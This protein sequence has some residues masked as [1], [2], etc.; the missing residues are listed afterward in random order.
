[1]LTAKNL[2][3]PAVSIG[4]RATVSEAAE[5]MKKQGTGVL[6]VQSGDRPLGIITDRDIAV[7]STADGL[8]PNTVPVEAVMTAEIAGC[9]EDTSADE[10]TS[11]MA[12]RELH[13]LPVFDRESRRVVGILTT[14]EIP[15][16]S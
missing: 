10:A 6:V 7:R 12:E 3:K 4:P 15:Q 8:N 5:T 14:S 9:L 16:P 2:M 11:I 1:M 13:R